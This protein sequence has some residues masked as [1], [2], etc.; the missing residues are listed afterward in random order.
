MQPQE[1][2]RVW[3][4]VKRDVAKRGIFARTS[5]GAIKNKRSKTQRNTLKTKHSC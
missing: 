4:K 2:L 3:W 5:F 1:N